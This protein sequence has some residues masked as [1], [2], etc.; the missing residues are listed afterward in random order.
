MEQCNA[1]PYVS[2][3]TVENEGS[4]M[5]GVHVDDIILSGKQGVCSEFLGQLK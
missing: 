1:K 5:V 2:R 3:E 4:L